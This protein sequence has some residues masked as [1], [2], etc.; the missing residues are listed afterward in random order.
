MSISL[1]TESTALLAKM[2][3]G[4]LFSTA[5]PSREVLRHIT[6]QWG[7]LVLVALLSGTHR[8]S[9]LRRKVGG[10]S[11][12]MLSQTLQSL[13]SDG[14]VVRVSRPVVPPH[15]EYSLSGMGVEVAHQVQGL[16]D[17]IEE[18]ISRIMMQR[19]IKKDESAATATPPGVTRHYI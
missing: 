14:F 2:R 13:E 8:F 19:Q 17:W 12:K 1:N 6:S 4:E 5:C 9:E 15:V 7:V 18:N 16:A 10:V 11:E 3:R